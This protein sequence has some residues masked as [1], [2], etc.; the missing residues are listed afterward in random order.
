MKPPAGLM[1]NKRQKIWQLK[2]ENKELRDCIKAL[3]DLYVIPYD[4]DTDEGG[5]IVV[6]SPR[7]SM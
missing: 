3:I 4:L 5:L 2:Q 6:H 1:G 7:G